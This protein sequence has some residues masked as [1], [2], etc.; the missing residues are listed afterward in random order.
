M[1]ADGVATGQC[2]CAGPL[3]IIITI[4]IALFILPTAGIIGLSHYPFHLLAYY[5]ISGTLIYVAYR[6]YKKHIQESVV[7]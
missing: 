5:A 7:K 6:I 1:M 2:A 3:D 4:F